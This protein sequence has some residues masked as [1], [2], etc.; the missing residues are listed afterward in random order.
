MK[1]SFDNSIKKHSMAKIIVMTTM[2]LVSLTNIFGVAAAGMSVLI[3][4]GAFIVF[5]IFEQQSFRECGLDLKSIKTTVNPTIWILIAMPT[6]I[7]IL[8]IVFAKLMLPE[9]ITHVIARSE[10]MLSA[11]K[12]PLL[13]IQLIILA[14]VEEVAWRGFFQKQIQSFL[15]ALPA[16]LG[17]SAIF[18]LGHMASG[19]FM[20]V[21]YDLLFVFINSLI[22]G[23]VF[24]KTNNVWLSTISHLLANLSAVFILLFL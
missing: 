17:T 6:I 10:S 3:G 23:V 5:K 13:L 15:P 9:Y 1:T 8:V 19:S 11:D 20:I 24:K 16:I 14:F 18:S 22:Y 21:A 2:V 12:L 7:N 4:V